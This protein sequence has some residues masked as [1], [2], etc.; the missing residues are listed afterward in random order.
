FWRLASDQRT[1]NALLT[2][3]GSALIAALVNVVF[4]LIVA[5]VLVRYSFRG[6]RLLDAI[7]DLP[8]ALPTA[9]AGIALSTLYGPKGWL[10][11]PLGLLGIKVSYTPL[12]IVIALIFIGLPF[13]VRT[14]QP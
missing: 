1:V 9:L 12:G 8:F 14:V 5:W 4:G 7:V 6:R 11:A 13:V 2:S 3:F 10:G